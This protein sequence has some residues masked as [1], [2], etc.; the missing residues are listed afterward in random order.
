MTRAIK[1]LLDGGQTHKAAFGWISVCPDPGSRQIAL[2]LV[3]WMG[4]RKRGG[5]RKDSFIDLLPFTR[6][7]KRTL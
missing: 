2:D 6:K 7:H 5:K 3:V 1:D 4:K